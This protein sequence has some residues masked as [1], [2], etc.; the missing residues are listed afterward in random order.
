MKTVVTFGEIMLRLSTPGYQRFLQATQFDINYG[1][2]EANV[3]VSLAQ[4]GLS[5]SYVTRLPNNAL[6]DS[7]LNSL[8]KFG[9][10]T[11]H[12]VRGGERMGTYF[13][14]TGASQRSSKIIYDR[15]ASSI[16]EITPGMIKWDDI[17]RNA[18]WFHITGITPALSNSCAETTVEAVKSARNN[19]V[20]ISC[21]LNYRKK[22]WSTEEAGIVMANILGYVDVL[23]ANEE[24]VQQLFG[25]I[26]QAATL[27]DEPARVRSI[28]EQLHQRFPTLQKIALTFRSGVTSTDNIVYGFLWDQHSIV[29]SKHYSIRI[30]DRVGG[31]DSFSAGLIYGF[32]SGLSQQD[33]LDFAA[34]ASCLKHTV[35]GDFNYCSVSEVNELIQ[36]NNG[37]RVQR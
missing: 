19:G 24:H 35:P 5:S 11:D 32:V 37:G 16:V 20:T 31:G 29:K 1:G 17:F 34:A 8:R 22:L 15:K 4:F 14:E 6:G 23:V 7:G 36:E 28:V 12:I 21:D 3:A 9:V 10:I 13:L 26:P 30:V 33:A 27:N 18:Q 25:I 2:G